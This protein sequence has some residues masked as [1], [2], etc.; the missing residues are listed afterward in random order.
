MNLVKITKYTYKKQ[1]NKI[2]VVNQKTEYSI[3]IFPIT[4]SP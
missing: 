4:T 2:P 3:F 1:V